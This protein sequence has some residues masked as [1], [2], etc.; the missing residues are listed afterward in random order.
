MR[1]LLVEVFRV[2]TPQKIP[3]SRSFYVNVKQLIP[4]AK[5]L[6]KALS[7]QFAFRRHSDPGL[8]PITAER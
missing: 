4:R 5:G 7:D 2:V 6:E 1:S 3:L 8:S